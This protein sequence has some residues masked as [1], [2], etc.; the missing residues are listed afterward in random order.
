MKL[1]ENF[2]IEEFCVSAS[3]PQLVQAVPFEYRAHVETLVLEILQPIRDHL[4]EPVTITSGYRPLA[5]N[6]AIG[7]SPTSQHLTAS[8]ADFTTAHLRGLF[9]EL[10]SRTLLV[11]CGQCIYYPS[12]GFIHIALP[13]AR[14]PLASFHVH[15][16]AAAIDYRRVKSLRELDSVLYG[17]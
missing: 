6:R 13:S 10:V 12:R 8:A 3:C 2:H 14:Y 9:R 15:E 16:P 11:P 1:S 7:G 17:L 5:L 4:G